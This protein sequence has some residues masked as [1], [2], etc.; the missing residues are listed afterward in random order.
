MGAALMIRRDL[1]SSDDLRRLARRERNRRTATRMLAIANAL[2]GLSRAEAARLVGLERQ[3]LPYV[4]R[5][6]TRARGNPVR[7][8]KAALAERL[9]VDQPPRGGPV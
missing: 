5:R 2:E 7:Q 1:V 3:A 8:R 6:L 4:A 9:E